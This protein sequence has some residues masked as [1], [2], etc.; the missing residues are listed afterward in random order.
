MCGRNRRGRDKT[1]VEKTF[2][3]R[4]AE[5]KAEVPAVTP[6]EAKEARER[7]PG[8]VFID[9][10]DADGIASST[11]MIPGALNLPLAMLNGSSEGNFPGELASRERPIITACQGG[12][13]GA[14]AAHALMRRGYTNVRFM[15]GGTQGWLDAG[16]ETVR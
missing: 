8:T 4:V 14:V 11:G 12:P 9:P 1:V 13:M 16:Y 10:R 15:E 6:R 3:E 5:A 2:A 7:E